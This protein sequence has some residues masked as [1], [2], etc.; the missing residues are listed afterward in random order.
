MRMWYWIWA[1]H[2]DMEKE[3]TGGVRP[4]CCVKHGPVA[5]WFSGTCNDFLL[6]ISPLTRSSRS[7]TQRRVRT[8][9]ERPTRH[10]R[11]DPMSPRPST[12]ACS[13]HHGEA[14]L[15]LSRQKDSKRVRARRRARRGMVWMVLLC[16]ESNNTHDQR[17]AR[18]KAAGVESGRGG[19]R[20][21][22]EK[23]KSRSNGRKP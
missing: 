3:G 5:R 15:V 4:S 1:A 23:K 11:V 20:S 19:P 17:R 7:T 16:F 8:V 18:D 21:T 13:S 12:L 6:T 22:C 9:Q 10:T 14:S 2:E